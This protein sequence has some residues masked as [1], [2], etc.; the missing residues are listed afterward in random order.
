MK[1]CL[2]AASI[3]LGLFTFSAKAQTISP[4]EKEIRQFSFSLY[5]E[6]KQ[7]PVALDRMSINDTMSLDRIPLLAKI[8]S[9][10]DKHAAAYYSSRSQS[11]EAVKGTIP[12]TKKFKAL[13]SLAMEDILSSFTMEDSTL[14]P[15]YALKT[16]ISADAVTNNLAT[17]M[18]IMLDEVGQEQTRSEKMRLYGAYVFSGLRITS[19]NLSG[20]IWRVW[21][22]GQW[23]VLD[24][25]WDIRKNKI[26][27]V[28]VWTKGN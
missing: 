19:Q 18:F 21:A 25:T 27:D 13:G 24:F 9:F 1:K 23:R 3:C 20:D 11:L 16:S 15:V 4:L 8:K 5:E 28:K 14:N 7:L 2:L 26:W 22:D 12:D 6:V 10:L 17:T